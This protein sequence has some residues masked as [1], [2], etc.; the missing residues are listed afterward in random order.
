MLNPLVGSNWLDHWNTPLHKNKKDKMVQYKSITANLKT[1]KA[2]VKLLVLLV[3]NKFYL[4]FDS[5]INLHLCGD[6]ENN[7]NGT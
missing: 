6:S 3:E 7:T 1:C 2:L 4:I 5:K